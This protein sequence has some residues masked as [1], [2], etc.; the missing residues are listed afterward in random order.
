MFATMAPE[1][2]FALAWMLT[3]ASV[4][5]GRVPGGE[6]RANKMLFDMF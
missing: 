1:H 6:G 2:R 4:G 5:A 3:M